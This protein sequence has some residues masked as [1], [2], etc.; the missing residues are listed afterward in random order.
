MAGAEPVTNVT[1]AFWASGESKPGVGWSSSLVSV[2]ADSP[3]P[4]LA[5]AAHSSAWLAPPKRIRSAA[6]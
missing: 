4:R 2:E 3:M 6:R 1:V 5:N